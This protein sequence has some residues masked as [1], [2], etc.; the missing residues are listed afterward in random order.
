MVNQ[1]QTLTD[2]GAP[3]RGA[4]KESRTSKRQGQNIVRSSELP[5]NA[6]ALT[7]Q[8]TSLVMDVTDWRWIPDELG[9]LAV[10]I[11]ARDVTRTGEAT[12]PMD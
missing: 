8:G 9:R 12:E 5:T 3:P 7:S 1:G 6:I 11:L 2:L 10:P 4:P